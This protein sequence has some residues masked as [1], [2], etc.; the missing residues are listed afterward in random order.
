MR[1]HMT[2]PTL[3]PDPLPELGHPSEP[4]AERIAAGMRNRRRVLGDQWVDQAQA[5]RNAFNGE[6][7]DLIAQYAWAEIWG[8]PALGD[9]ARRLMVLS[10][11]IALGAWSEFEM[12]VNAALEAATTAG[13]LS[14]DDIKEVILQSAIYCGLPAANHAFK[15]AQGVLRARGG[16][17]RGA[18]AV[19]VPEMSQK[20]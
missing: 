16:A 10:S 5:G 8:R 11:L 19:R 14:A 4:A 7:Q 3:Q 17:E 2:N 12:H 13:G 15:L 9:R 20:Q 6:F 18:Q 1:V